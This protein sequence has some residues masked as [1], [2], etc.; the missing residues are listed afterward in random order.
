VSKVLEGNV[1]DAVLVKWCIVSATS[2]TFGS[3]GRCQR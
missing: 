2:Q 1:R 3:W